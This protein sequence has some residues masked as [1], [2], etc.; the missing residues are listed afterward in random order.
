M[1]FRGCGPCDPDDPDA[2]EPCVPGVDDVA[3]ISNVLYE[4]VYI[5][6]PSQFALFIGP[7]QQYIINRHGPHSDKSTDKFLKQLV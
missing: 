1:K 2:D 7:A 5:E 6:Q 4:N 3:R